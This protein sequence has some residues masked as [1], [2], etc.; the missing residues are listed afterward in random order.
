G[1]RER[2][3]QVRAYEPLGTGDGYRHPA[4]LAPAPVAGGLE[5]VPV[6]VDL[7]QDRLRDD[8]EQGREEEARQQVAGREPLEAEGPEPQGQVDAEGV[9]PQ[10]DEQEQGHVTEPA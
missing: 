1:R 8:A 4:L 3:D 6:V 5:V 9:E 2:L 7:A 10:C